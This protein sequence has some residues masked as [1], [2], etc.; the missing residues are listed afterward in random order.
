MGGWSRPSSHLIMEEHMGMEIPGITRI[1]PEFNQN[2]KLTNNVQQKKERPSKE[3]ETPLDPKELQQAL[4]NIEKLIS[5]FNRRFKIR[6][7]NDIN[8]IIVKVIDRETD[9]VIKKFIPAND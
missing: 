7:D 3:V 9:K 8:R 2:E 1:Q 6:V 4:R 5:H